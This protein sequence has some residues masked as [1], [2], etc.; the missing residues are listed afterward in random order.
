[1]RIAKTGLQVFVTKLPDFRIAEPYSAVV[2]DGD[3]QERL[4]TAAGFIFRT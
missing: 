1:M 4:T 2:G 3:G